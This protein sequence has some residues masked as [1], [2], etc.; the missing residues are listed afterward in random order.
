M[1]AVVAKLMAKLSV[2]VSTADA[3]ADGQSAFHVD[4][5]N[6]I[7]RR[8]PVPGAVDAWSRGS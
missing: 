6:L 3:R 1:A 4:Q 7:Q 8:W 2:E 5:L